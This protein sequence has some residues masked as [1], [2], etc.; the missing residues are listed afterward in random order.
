[1]VF[2]RIHRCVCERQ[3][4]SGTK[5]F[6]FRDKSGIFRPHLFIYLLQPK[7]REFLEYVGFV[8]LL[9]KLFIH[10]CRKQKGKGQDI[11]AIIASLIHTM[12][13]DLCHVLHQDVQSLSPESRWSHICALVLCVAR[14]LHPTELPNLVD[15]QNVSW[16]ILKE[17]SD[18]V[19]T[20][21]SPLATHVVNLH[22]STDVLIR[23][24]TVSGVNYSNGVYLL[25]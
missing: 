9:V 1:M 2:Y 18:G 7:I 6:R 16:T 4:E 17:T 25:Q 21:V 23:D 11:E 8:P 19:L 5:T 14:G 15:K 13:R 3:H 12:T 10:E 24:V 22:L 20:S